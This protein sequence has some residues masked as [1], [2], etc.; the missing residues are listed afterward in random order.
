MAGR[1]GGGGTEAGSAG[2]EAGRVGRGRSG[3][4]VGGKRAPGGEGAAGF[5]ISECVKPAEAVG[6]G[7]LGVHLLHVEVAYIDIYKSIEPTCPVWVA[8]SAICNTSIAQED[9]LFP[10]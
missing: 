10:R 5:I 8:R 1:S 3:G 9:A 6:K 2:G 7:T 4:R